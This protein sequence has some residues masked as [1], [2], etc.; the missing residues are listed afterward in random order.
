MNLKFVQSMSMHHSH[1]V[2]FNDRNLMMFLTYF[3]YISYNNRFD[4][5]RVLKDTL[6]LNEVSALYVRHGS[7]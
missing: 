6:K 3:D 2:F 4:T 7:V 1:V 5:F